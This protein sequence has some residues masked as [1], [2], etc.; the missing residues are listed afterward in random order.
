[1][2]NGWTAADFGDSPP[3]CNDVTGPGGL[4]A[5]GITSSSAV[6]HWDEVDLAD[7]YIVAF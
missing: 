1:M 5:D 2:Y 6:M 7:Q 4:F 3:V